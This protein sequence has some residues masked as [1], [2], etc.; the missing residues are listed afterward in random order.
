MRST[1]TD[2]LKT[3]GRKTLRETIFGAEVAGSWNNSLIPFED[4]ICPQSNYFI[5]YDASYL[6][7]TRGCHVPLLLEI[8]GYIWAAFSF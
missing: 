3:Q 8:G 7:L 5:L 2:H 6:V 4:A 1:W